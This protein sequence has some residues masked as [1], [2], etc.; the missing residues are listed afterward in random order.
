MYAIKTFSKDASLDEMHKAAVE[1][2]VFLI[3]KLFGR[4]ALRSSSQRSSK[5]D[6]NKGD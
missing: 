1:D 4:R 5:A 3:E 2:G 6:Q